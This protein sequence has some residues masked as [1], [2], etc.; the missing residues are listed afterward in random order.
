MWNAIGDRPGF[1]HGFKHR[2]ESCDLSEH[3]CKV[4]DI[5]RST[6]AAGTELTS[7]AHFKGCEQETH[8]LQLQLKRKLDELGLYHKKEREAWA[9][10]KESLKKEIREIKAGE[11]RGI[12]LELKTILEIIQTEQRKEEKKWTD[13]LL[14]FLNDRCAW[15]IQ[16]TEFNYTSQEEAYAVKPCTDRTFSSLKEAHREEKKDQKRLLEDTHAAAMEL[17]RQLE[18]NERNWKVE[19]MELLE[20]FDSERKEWECQW[21]IMQKKIEELYQEVKLRRENRLNENEEGNQ[22]KRGPMS[23]SYPETSVAGDTA[24]QIEKQNTVNHLLNANRQLS[25]QCLNSTDMKSHGLEII[26]QKHNVLKLESE[27]DLVQKMSKTEN[28]TLNDALREIARVSEEL[29]KY[30]EEIREKSTCKRHRAVSVSVTHES[31]EPINMQ[32]NKDKDV[33]VSSPRKAKLK[34]QFHENN[35]KTRKNMETIMNDSPFNEQDPSVPP[36]CFSWHFA[37]SGFSEMEKTPSSSSDLGSGQKSA[38]SGKNDDDVS[39]GIA[40]D[41]LYDGYSHVQWL[42][43]IEKLEDEVLTESI[44]NNVLDSSI[45]STQLEDQNGAFTENRILYSNSLYPDRI[46]VGQSSSGYGCNYENPMKNGKLEAKID[47]FN[48]IV[49]KTGKGSATLHEPALDLFLTEN[50][51]ESIRSKSDVPNTDK[52]NTNPTR[53]KEVSA[54]VCGNNTLHTCNNVKS[55]S[56]HDHTA[57]SHKASS[58]QYMFQEHKWRPINLSGRPRSA[59]SRSNYGVVEKLL[60]SYESKTASSFSNPKHFLDKRTHS[61]ILLTENSTDAFTHFIEVLKLDQTSKHD[62]S[63]HWKLGQEAFGLKLPEMPLLG[64]NQ[65][66][67][68]FSRPARPANRRPPSRWASTR[69]PS[70]PASLRRTTN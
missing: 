60:K 59:D 37:K 11:Y 9:K 24:R 23:I 64:T 36:W 12:L 19:K 16:R 62:M 39:S 48:R 50:Q 52:T 42:C 3:R 41:N 20:R 54:Q 46:I 14:Q 66:A 26:C 57:G 2:Y 32:L 17:R 43:D 33:P 7:G 63:V 61:D 25:A 53:V 10:E 45:V 1:C 6:D 28:D 51:K 31:K 22:R 58:Y 68:G 49:F 8:E 69:S 40:L 35:L 30:Q 44:L 55:T 5:I 29:C 18:N 4:R 56:L 21:K 47:E 38:T 27:K 34:Q 67:K 70:M 13:V 65:S 15:D